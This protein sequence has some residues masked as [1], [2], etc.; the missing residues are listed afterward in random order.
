MRCSKFWLLLM[1]F[2]TVLTCTAGV[3][4]KK[5]SL[6]QDPVLTEACNLAKR[7]LGERAAGFIF[8][9]SGNDTLRNAFEITSSGKK[10]VIRGNSGIDLASGLNWYLKNYCNAQFTV[11]DSHL[12]LPDP[13]PLPQ[14]PIIVRTP[15]RYRYF[16]NVCT[17][18]YTMAWWSWKEWERQIDWMA[19]NGINL[20]LAITGQEEVWYEVYKEL[21]LT[22]AQ[23]DQFITGPAYFAWGWMGNIDGL[24]GPLPG[25]WRESH[26][27]LQKQIVNR[28]RALG[29]SPVLQGFTG[30]VPESLSKI[31]PAAK[32]HKTGKWSAGFDGTFFLDPGDTL[33]Q[34]IGRLFIEKQADLY[35]TSHYYSADCFNEVD[36][37]SNDTLF[38]ANMSR[39]V[40]RA[41]SS[42]DPRAVWVLQA[43]FLYYNKEFWKE[44]QSKAFINAVPDDKMI[45]L[46]LWGER[47]PVWKSRSSFYG[48]PWIWNVLYNFGGRTCLS[49]NINAITE[50]YK[51]VLESPQKGNFSGIGMTMEYFGNNPVIEEFVMDRVWNKGIP[52]GKTWISGYVKDRYG[53]KNEHAEK[54]W[55]GMLATVYNTHKLNGTF[56]CERPGFFDPKKNYRSNPVIAYSQDTLIAA[57]EELMKCSP[58]FQNLET[59]Q[60]DLV[61]LARQVLSLLA[62]VWIR[63]TEKAFNEKDAIKLKKY[64]DLYLGLISD[65]DDLLATRKEYLLGSWV[66]NAKS[67]GTTQAERDL[68]EWNAKN[69][70][71]LWG[72][73]CTEGQD[74]DL[75]NYAVK[76]WSGMFRSYHLVRWTKFFDEMEAAVRKNEPWDRS[77]FYAESCEW[78]KVWSSKHEAFPTQPKG[79]PVSEAERIWLKYKVYF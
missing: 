46:D 37:D 53:K 23:I 30:H 14:L 1:I 54:A 44:P 4:A 65:F 35:G 70:I 24:G 39:S 2:A 42:A 28:E 45:L 50:N 79:N 41:M 47:F 20:P 25:S 72:K 67:W 36:P 63:E 15:Y 51:D 68:Y 77:H 73:G 49:G 75:N 78:E 57:F 6:V 66:E 38:L 13:L 11:T 71:T 76:Q 61:N 52:D 9:K 12:D 3:K 58:E 34:R 32:I 69:Q 5:K 27:E 29:M 26:K 10:I 40:Y 17:F 62:L 22:E 7:V 8:E 31:F 21:G 59:Y 55:L 56:L 64:R 18:G 60:F 33:F 16:F 43:W 19:M 74:D 48:K